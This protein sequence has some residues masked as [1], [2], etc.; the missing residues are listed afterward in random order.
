MAKLRAE[1]AELRQAGKNEK[2]E[3]EVTTEDSG[4]G[5]NIAELI[6]ALAKLEKAVGP[7]HSLVTAAR[8]ELEE[9]RRKRD[10]AKPARFKISALQK[11]RG[12]KKEAADAADKK[13]GDLRE[14]AKKAEEAV[15][16]GTRLR[17]ELATEVGEIEEELFRMR[18]EEL[19]AKK[20]TNEVPKNDTIFRGLARNSSHYQ[21]VEM[22]TKRS[23]E[24]RRLWRG[25][26]SREPARQQ[27]FRNT[28]R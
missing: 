13:V 10:E 24:L 22:S 27:R 23:S 17:D 5:T 7:S 16:E 28:L 3:E 4:G 11:K 14:A 12:K 25:C 15:K 20:K 26:V 2:I 1:I 19:H 18:E 8:I 21:R 9:A 6:G